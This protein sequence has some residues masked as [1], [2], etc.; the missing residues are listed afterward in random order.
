MESLPHQDLRKP[1]FTP[2]QARA[3]VCLVR[4]TLNTPEGQTK[5]TAIR[6]RLQRER[7]SS[8]DGIEKNQITI[9]GA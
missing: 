1:V 5:L 9:G 3:F 4:A 2:E 7:A 8:Q 6:L